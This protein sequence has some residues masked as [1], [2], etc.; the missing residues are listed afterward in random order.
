MMSLLGL[1]IVVV[2]IA[3]VFAGW[4]EWRAYATYRRRKCAGALWR[5][6]FPSASKSEIRLFLSCLV[7]GMGFPRKIRLQFQPG[8]EVV[9]IYRSLYGGKTPLADSM[10]CEKVAQLLAHEFKIPLNE[11]LA[12]WHEE[13][14][15]ADLFAVVRRSPGV[16]PNL[17]IE[18]AREG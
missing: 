17:R 1:L 8:D 9:S 7:D 6:E 2:V 11:I 14:A 5:H 15:L 10:E 18:R 16:L 12:Q 13:V 3:G 4:P